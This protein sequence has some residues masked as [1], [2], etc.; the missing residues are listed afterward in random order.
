MIIEGYSLNL[1]LK[2]YNLGYITIL[3]RTFALAY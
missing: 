3:Y 1:R 2:R